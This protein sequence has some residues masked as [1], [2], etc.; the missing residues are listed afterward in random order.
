MHDGPSHLDEPKHQD[1][2]ALF[3]KCVGSTKFSRDS[4]SRDL[5]SGL[6]SLSAECVAKEGLNP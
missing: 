1:Y 4:I 5:T 2:S 6:T 3:K